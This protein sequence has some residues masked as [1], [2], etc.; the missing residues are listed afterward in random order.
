MGPYK[1]YIFIFFIGVVCI[2]GFSKVIF[3]VPFFWA[4]IFWGVGMVIHQLYRVARLATDEWAMKRADELVDGSYDL[5]HI[6]NIRER[7]TKTSK[8]ELKK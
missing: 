3:P 1:S 5:S 6:E 7:R 4:V 2:F 8:V